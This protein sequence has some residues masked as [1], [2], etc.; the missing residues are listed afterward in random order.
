MFDQAFARIATGFS[1]MAGGPFSDAVVTWAG[2]P[3]KDAGGSITTP[4]TPVSLDCKA[5][6]DAPTQAMRAAEG[7]LESDAR[8]IVLAASL[9]GGLDTTARIVKATGPYAGT[10][11]LLSVAGDPAGVGYECR[12]RRVG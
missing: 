7:F 10:W 2:T 1:A 5:Q 8:V 11:A 6:F 9:A 4:G 3:V 12:A